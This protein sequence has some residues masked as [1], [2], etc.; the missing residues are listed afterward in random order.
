M[1]S[2][3][4]D[5]WELGDEAPTQVVTFN[6]VPCRWHSGLLVEAADLTHG[7][8]YE[9]DTETGEIHRLTTGEATRRGTP[10]AEAAAARKSANAFGKKG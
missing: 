6:G 8:Y 4:A 10:W 5:R 9:I 1:G 3:V 2:K 7:A